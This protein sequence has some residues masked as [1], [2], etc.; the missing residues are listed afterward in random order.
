MGKLLGIP[1]NYESYNVKTD[2]SVITFTITREN[3]DCK[4]LLLLVGVI[5]RLQLL[6]HLVVDGKRF[7]CG[8]IGFIQQ[9]RVGFD[10]DLVFLGHKTQC[11]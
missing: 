3:N 11:S 5:S 4:M 9:R 8:F 10:I 7:F 6:R 2:C 1:A